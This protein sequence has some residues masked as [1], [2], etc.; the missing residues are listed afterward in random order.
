MI[1]RRKK[2]TLNKKPLEYYLIFEVAAVD[3]LIYTASHLIYQSI[4]RLI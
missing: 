3:N 2:I 4:I 1:S